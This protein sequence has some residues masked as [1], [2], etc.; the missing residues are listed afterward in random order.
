M[1]HAN[2]K[3]VRAPGSRAAAQQRGVSRPRIAVAAQWDAATGHGKLPLHYL[4]ALMGA[5]AE[6][7]VA[8]PFAMD[9]TPAASPG[10]A[11]VAC[12]QGLDPADASVLEGAAGLLIPGGG[13]IDP[14]W[15]GRDRHPR[16]TKV[17]HVRDTFEATLLE[18]ALGDDLAVLCICHGMQMLN[19]HHGGTLIQH[20]AD[21]GSRLEHDRDRPRA[22][23]VHEVRIEPG[24]RVH[25]AV[26]AERVAVN[27][28]HHQ[29]I[30][31]TGEG[32]REVAWADD[33]VV[34]ALEATGRSWVVGVQWHPEVMAPLDARQRALFERFVAA[35]RRSG[36][37][38]GDAA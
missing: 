28:H 34:E 25:R 20:L 4:A 24:S 2:H 35:A 5:G 19:V 33:G 21:D 30:E 27:S 15:Y 9:P 37:R 11:D 6:P 18:A 23:P 3:G 8:T 7:V 38:E 1:G 31:R 10:L 16:T 26:G 36:R 14:A 32:L 13:D 12:L 17:S 22:E 29:G